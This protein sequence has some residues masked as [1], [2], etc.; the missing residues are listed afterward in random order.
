MPK[1][2]HYQLVFQVEY[3]A[4]VAVD[5]NITPEQAMKMIPLPTEDIRETDDFFYHLSLDTGS[6][7]LVRAEEGPWGV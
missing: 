5:S 2:K 3:A 1:T 4:S 6:L 7:K